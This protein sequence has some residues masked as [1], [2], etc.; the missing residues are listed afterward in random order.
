MNAKQNNPAVIPG[1][2][3]KGAKQRRFVS[4]TQRIARVEALRSERNHLMVELY[5]DG[6]LQKDLTA[7]TN[8]ALESEGA[9]PVTDRSVSQQLR[10]LLPG[11]DGRRKRFGHAN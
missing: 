10:R 7:L 2:E 5:E 3:P 11:V 1:V 9:A 6:L 8:F 4:L